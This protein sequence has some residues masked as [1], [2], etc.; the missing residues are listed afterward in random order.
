MFLSSPVWIT[1]KWKGAT[2]S[3]MIEEECGAG[4]YGPGGTELT[5]TLGTYVYTP[6]R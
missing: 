3:M 1:A 2:E 5:R 4:P 6:T